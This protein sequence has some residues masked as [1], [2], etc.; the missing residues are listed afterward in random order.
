MAPFMW[1][2]TRQWPP[3]IHD[4]KLDAIEDLLEELNGEPLLVAYEF[5][6]DFDRLRDR[7]G[8]VDQEDGAKVLSRI[9]A[10]APPPSRKRTG[11]R[12][13]TAASC[14]CCAPTPPAPATG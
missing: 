11:S 6:H 5:N 8:V 12:L 13:G 1:A 10:R 7:F 2:M 3:V 4:L 14:P 9:W